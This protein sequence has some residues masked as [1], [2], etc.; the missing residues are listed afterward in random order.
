MDQMRKFFMRNIKGTLMR[1]DNEL[2]YGRS[3]VGKI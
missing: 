1:E 2:E 3:M